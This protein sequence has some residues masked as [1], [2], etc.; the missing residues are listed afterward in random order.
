MRVGIVILPEYRWWAAEP[1]WR[2]AEEYGFAHAWTYDHLGWRSLVD[3]PWFDA[4]PTLTAAAAVTS[5]IR[6]GTLVAS[7]NFRHPAHFA[8]EL[9]AL[10]DISDGRIT[11]GVGAGGIGFD[12]QV[13]GYAELSPRQRVDRFTEFVELLD[14]ILTRD[15]TEYSGRYYSAV[16]AHRA[17]GC[18]QL[19]R[20]PFVVAAN[21]PRSMRL[22]VQYGQGWVTT[23]HQAEDLEAWWRSVAEL[24]L[25]FADVLAEQGRDPATVDKYLQVDAAPVYSMSSVDNFRDVVGRAAE[26]GFTDVITHW[27]RA[28][29]PYAGKEATVEEIASEVLPEL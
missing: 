6:L 22:A 29:E 26:L 23:G 15:G 2:M 7:P 14:Q 18:V 16:H 3:K 11:V 8:R 17:P 10:D 27:P 21:G 4:I 20:L 19:P 24:S 13:L 28:E 25:R 12:T 5:T 1:L 9:T